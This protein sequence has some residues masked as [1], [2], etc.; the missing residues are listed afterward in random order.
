[1]A[2]SMIEVQYTAG[3][4]SRMRDA[5]ANLIVAHLENQL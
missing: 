1:V 5:V 3:V 2:D 4:V